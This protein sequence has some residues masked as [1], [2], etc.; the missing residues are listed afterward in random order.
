MTF[1]A[2]KHCKLQ[3]FLSTRTP[4]R[5][6]A[7]GEA[8]HITF[9]YHRRPPARTRARG[10]R[11]DLRAAAPAADPGSLRLSKFHPGLIWTCCECHP[12]AMIRIARCS[13]DPVYIDRLEQ[14]RANIRRG[15]YRLFCT[16]S[17]D[18][19]EILLLAA[20]RRTG[21]GGCCC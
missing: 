17:R 3:G 21:G 12:M 7:A 10:R 4:Y 2:K 19:R 1:K 14:N 6:S 20:A 8:A 16:L 9:G 18:C 5:G 11:P 15:M 13:F